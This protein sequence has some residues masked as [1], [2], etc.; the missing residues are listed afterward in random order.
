MEQHKLTL[1]PE[2][3]L[4]QALRLYYSAKEL[5]AAA[6]RK[7]HPALTEAEINE[8]VKEIFLHART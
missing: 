3:K 8:K 7:F 5:K 1:T 6:I 4:Y 2:Q